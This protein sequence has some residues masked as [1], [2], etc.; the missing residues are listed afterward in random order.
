MLAFLNGIVAS[1]ILNMYN[2]TLNTTVGDILSLPVQFKK[3]E[4][5]EPIAEKNVE[6]SQTDWDSFETSWDFQH[7][8]LLR[9]V[10]TIA[11]AFEQ[12]KTECDDRFNQLKTNEEELTVFSLTFMACRTS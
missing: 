9:K 6:L 10:S 1:T 2:P 11:E 3:R 4:Q 8:P 12:W 7:H 5:I